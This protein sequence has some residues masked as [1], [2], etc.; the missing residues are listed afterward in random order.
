VYAII[1]A[2]GK[3]YRVMQNDIIAV[4]GLAANEG[5]EIV[6]NE[7]MLVSD[8]KGV[9]IGSPYVVGAK[10]VGK[11][12]KHYKGRKI[13]GFTYKPKKDERRRYGHRQYLTSLAITDIRG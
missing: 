10:V 6:I 2:G 4:N 13:N 3:Q 1:K 8:D 12:M 11:V 9:N 5:D 7:V